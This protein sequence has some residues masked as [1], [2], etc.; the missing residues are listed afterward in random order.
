MLKKEFLL[1][2]KEE[3]IQLYITENR[4]VKEVAE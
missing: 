1:K 4:T 2:N 3:V